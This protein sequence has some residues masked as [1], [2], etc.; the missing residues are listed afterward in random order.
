[1]EFREDRDVLEFHREHQLS[2]K[3]LSMDMLV[4]KKTADATLHNNIGRIFRKYNV[5]EYKSPRDS[6]GIDQFYK[7]LSYACLYKSLGQHADE[8]KAD[9]L[10]LTFIRQSAP[11]G[12]FTSLQAY[13]HTVTKQYSGIYYVTDSLMFPIQII[14][15]SEL[16]SSD[17]LSLRVLSDK[18]DE[19]DAKEFIERASFYESQGDMENA[20]ALLSISESANQKIFEEIREE[21]NMNQVMQN[22]FRKEIDAAKKQAVDEATAE[23]RAKARA[24]KA[25]AE[26]RQKELEEENKKLREE[27]K[28]LNEKL[29][30]AML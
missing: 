7:G 1:M 3:A 30:L 5:V 21:N 2:K 14:V 23:V 28:R 26:A 25:E 13:G 18:A 9:E 8:I 11:R 27:N 10:T 17:H 16:E 20:E 6:L 15:S 19:R 29:K 22:F 4:V 24:A 12:L